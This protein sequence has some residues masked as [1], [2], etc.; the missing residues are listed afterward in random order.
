M[1]PAVHKK[2][3]VSKYSITSKS[4]SCWRTEMACG[5][6]FGRF[7]RAWIPQYHSHMSGIYASRSKYI[8]VDPNAVEIIT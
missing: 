2:C 4:Y 3:T 5:G 8:Y 6:R 7:G 1:V